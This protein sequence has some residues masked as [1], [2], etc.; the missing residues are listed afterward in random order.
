MVGG[1]LKMTLLYQAAGFF[2]HGKMK[3]VQRPSVYYVKINITTNGFEFIGAYAT[4]ALIDK[5]SAGYRLDIPWSNIKIINKTKARAMHTVT[6]ETSDT[7]YTILPVDPDNIAFNPISQSKR[8]A[9]E[10]LDII[11]KAQDQVK[12]L[13]ESK[14]SNLIICSACGVEV[15]SSSKFC[16]NC[17][18]KI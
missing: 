10:L 11:T 4:F 8:C 12:G 9:W 6:I 3:M 16:K 1:S 17:G 15:A 18:H 2:T 5:N 13:Q 7:F 14:E